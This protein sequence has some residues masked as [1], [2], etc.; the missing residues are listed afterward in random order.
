MMLR[1]QSWTF[2]S[3]INTDLIFPKPFFRSVY[4]PGEMASHLMAGIDEGFAQKVSPGDIIVGGPNFG[5]GSSREEAVAAMREAGIAAVVAPSFGRLFMRNGI[6]FGI[7]II[8][9]AGI[10][11]QV[12]E[13]DMLEIDL[14]AGQLL[15]TT[16]GYHATL[17]PMAPESLRM[18]REGGI[19]AYTQRILLER[20]G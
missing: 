18:M 11:Q 3:N 20:R 1:G 19:K 7:P 8:A 17:A 14:D 15:N 13:G 16:T 5:C 6:N 4:E 10:D 9:L 12:S 2:G